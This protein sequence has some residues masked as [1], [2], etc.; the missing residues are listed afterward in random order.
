MFNVYVILYEIQY[1]IFIKISHLLTYINSIKSVG[2]SVVE[3]HFLGMLQNIFL[4][5]FIKI[6]QNLTHIFAIEYTYTHIE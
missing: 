5:H 4:L 3:N 6:T 2:Q 1:F